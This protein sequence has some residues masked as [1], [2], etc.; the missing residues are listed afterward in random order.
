[1]SKYSKFF[2]I[3]AVIVL[4]LSSWTI[5]YHL[6]GPESIYL[7]VFGLL[8]LFRGNLRFENSKLFYACIFGLLIIWN[9]LPRGSSSVNEGIGSSLANILVLP[10]L[11]LINNSDREKIYELLVRFLVIIVG[12][13]LFFHTFQLIG[14]QILDPISTGDILI[15]GRSFVVYPTHSNEIERGIEITRFSSIFDEP[16]YLGTLIAFLLCIEGYDLSKKRNR[17]LL[18][19][20]IFTLSGAFYTLSIINFVL[21]ALFLRNLKNLLT[22]LSFIFFLITLIYLL[23]PDIFSVVTD[24]L[25]LEEGKGLEDSRANISTF[26]QYIN[27]LYSLDSA[28]LLWGEGRFAE[29]D[30]YGIS[31]SHVSWVHLVLRIGC[32]FFFYLLA[33]FIV[34]IIRIKNSDTFI[35][36]S[37][38]T[39]SINHRPQIFNPIYFFLITCA[40]FLIP[41]RGKAV[42]NYVGPT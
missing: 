15:N 36:L 25:V 7:A 6:P 38:F 16:G 21:K 32:V 5:Y 18:L 26:R 24:R 20:G 14:F 12:V 10:A 4:V 39:I 28:T 3:Y 34:T 9:F 11:F 40:I 35:F 27:Y 17:I 41:L 23:F 1:M 33:L 30:K 22:S 2:Y 31:L 19:C 42:K 13:G 29:P 37:L 8:I